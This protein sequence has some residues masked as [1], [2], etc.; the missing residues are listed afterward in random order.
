MELD[1]NSRT[2][3]QPAEFWIVIALVVG[4]VALV[5]IQGALDLNLISEKA[6]AFGL[7]ALSALAVVVARRR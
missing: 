1:S 4:L 3:K 6:A 2:K 5:F 7:I